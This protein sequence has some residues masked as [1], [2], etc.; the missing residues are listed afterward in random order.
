MITTGHNLVACGDSITFGF[1]LSPWL[2]WPKILGR[3]VIGRDVANL[4]V[5][6]ATVADLPKLARPANGAGDCFVMIGSNDIFLY[7]QTAAVTLAALAPWV[8]AREA[9]GWT[10]YV[11]CSP[12]RNGTAGQKAELADYN[13]T[14]VSTYD[15]PDIS[16]DNRVGGLADPLNPAYF[17]DGIHPTAAGQQVLADFAATKWP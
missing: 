1:G 3:D 4:G 2:A 17:Q 11:Q 15:A 13:A 7:N 5:S 12:I 10:V 14:L 16:L 8:S 9:D 6:F